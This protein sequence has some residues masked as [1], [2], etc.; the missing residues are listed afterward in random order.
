MTSF[1]RQGSIETKQS[2]HLFAFLSIDCIV[3]IYI[4][5]YVCRYECMHDSRRIKRSGGEK[6]KRRNE[7]IYTDLFGLLAIVGDNES[8][9]DLFVSRDDR[10]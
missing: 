2:S 5:M 9:D 1:R 7:R 4:Y 8:D 10:A 6:K 3:C